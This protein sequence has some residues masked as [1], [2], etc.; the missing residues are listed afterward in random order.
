MYVEL[1]QCLCLQ[2]DSCTGRAAAAI[3]FRGGC[4]ETRRFV[5]VYTMWY[6]Y[7]LLTHLCMGY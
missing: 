7:V 4:G 3:V 2:L 5:L 1:W 6:F